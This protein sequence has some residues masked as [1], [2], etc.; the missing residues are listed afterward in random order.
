MKKYEAMFIFYPNV[1]EE[2]REKF[3]ERF[4]KVIEE[5]GK[6]EE[7]EEWGN[8]KLAY[9][10]EDLTEGYYVLLNFE[11][12]PSNVVELERLVKIS[13]VVMRHMIINKGE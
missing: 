8:R 10:I 4:T 6:I 7:R 3:L 11:I 13:D 2:E 12:E 1:E 9:T 5:N